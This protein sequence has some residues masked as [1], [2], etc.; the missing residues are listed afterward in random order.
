MVS[1]DAPEETNVKQEQR[2]TARSRVLKGGQIIFDSIVY[3]CIVLDISISGAR[4]RFHMP[5]P[6]PEIVTLR[7]RD[8]STYPAR[9]C[10]ARGSEIGLAFT[11]S[12]VASGDQGHSRRAWEALEALRGANPAG[13]VDILRDERYFGD[14]TLRHAAEAAEDAYTRLAEALKPHAEKAVRTRSKTA[15]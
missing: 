14:E 6:I 3:D 8:G 2:R 10:W 12:P 1:K 11:G 4:V 9:R 13:C 5:V 7:L 15:E